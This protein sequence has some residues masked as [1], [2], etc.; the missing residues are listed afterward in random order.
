MSYGKDERDVDTRVWEPPIPRY[1]HEDLVHQRLA[2][3]G[4]QEALLVAG[5]DLDEKS[6]FV[7]LRQKVRVALAAGS[8]AAEVTDIVTEMLG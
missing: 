3:L 6:N 7:A 8:A 5:L 1:D 2:A 4:Q